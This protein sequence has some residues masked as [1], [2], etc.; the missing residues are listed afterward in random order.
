MTDEDQNQNTKPALV[1]FDN[2]IK[3][4]AKLTFYGTPDQRAA[5]CAA[6]AKAQ[7]EY[8]PLKRTRSVAVQLPGGGSYTFDYAPLEEVIAGTRPAL[9]AHGLAYSS[10]SEDAANPDDNGEFLHTMLTHAGGAMMHSI[11]YVR[12]TAK[13]QER[14][15]IRTFK[16]RYQ[17]QSVVGVAAEFDDDANAADGNTLKGMKDK[18]PAA[19][20][21]PAPQ[22][23]APKAAPVKAVSARAVAPA[24]KAAPVVDRDDDQPPHPADGPEPHTEIVEPD[25]NGPATDVQQ[26]R[27]VELKAALQIAAPAGKEILKRY[28][29]DTM[30]PKFGE[31][32]AMIVDMEHAAT[33]AGDNRR[34]A[35]LELSG[36]L[37]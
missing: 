33:L 16:I 37:A 26:R 28:C 27:F 20:P 23:P 5:Y 19:R 36:S 12:P 4:G 6:L 35:V 10:W 3:L 30:S 18:A 34:K 13:E 22:A 15:G 14:G 21:A 11:E 32:Y 7:G 29:K 9:S 24:P 8:L 2:V 17:Y 1:P 31:I 25:E